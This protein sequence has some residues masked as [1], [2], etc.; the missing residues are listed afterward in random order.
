L[1]KYNC[2]IPCAT[3]YDKHDW[4]P[5]IKNLSSYNNCINKLKLKNCDNDLLKMFSLERFTDMYVGKIKTIG[6]YNMLMSLYADELSN[7]NLL[8]SS[9]KM[10]VKG[11]LLQD[12]VLQ[13]YHSSHK[14]KNMLTDCKYNILEDYIN[15]S[16]TLLKPILDFL[17]KHDLLVLCLQY[18]SFDKDT[19]RVIR[20]ITDYEIDQ[21]TK[22]VKGNTIA[23]VL[24]NDNMDLLN[25]N[26]LGKLQFHDE[27]NDFGMRPVDYLETTIN[28]SS[29]YDDVK[30]A[31]NVKLYTTIVKGSK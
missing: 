2:T 9:K 23:H 28:N 22:D 1:L 19:S 16:Y 15:F 6:D 5:A 13:D 29:K 7:I 21:Y 11:K 3:F 12:A 24:F 31:R 10:L 18:I 27:Y 8:D 17:H 30:L 25:E 26:I 20:I 14:I 4:C